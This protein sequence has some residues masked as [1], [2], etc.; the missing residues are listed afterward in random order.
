M[1]KFAWTGIL[2]LLLCSAGCI[3]KVIDFDALRAKREYSTEIA[4]DVLIHYSDSAQLRVRIEGPVLKRNIYRFKIEEEFPE[5]V[6]V[7]FYNGEGRP[8]AWL[9]ADY[10]IR[11]QNEKVVIVRGNVVLFNDAGDRLETHELTWNEAEE[12]LTTEQLVKIT[13]STDEVI[14]SRGFRTNQSFTEYEL[15]AVEGEMIIK[16]PNAP[17]IQ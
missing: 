3:E 2:A 7:E 13:R 4:T 10:A 15:F 12:K 16:D 1:N 14:W 6:A 5:G 11:R 9:E 17:S 8:N